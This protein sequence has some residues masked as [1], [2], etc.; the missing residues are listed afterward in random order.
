[1]IQHFTH[2]NYSYKANFLIRD[3]NNKRCLPDGRKEIKGQ[4][5]LKICQSE[6]DA[7]ALDR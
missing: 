5:R 4:E 7:L 1:M 2:K 6:E 3:R